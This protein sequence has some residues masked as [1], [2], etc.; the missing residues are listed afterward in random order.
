MKIIEENKWIIM[1]KDRK[2]IAKGIPRSRY[3]VP[4][5]DGTINKRLLTYSSKKRAESGFKNSWFYRR[6]I[7]VNYKEEDLE[8]IKIKITIEELEEANE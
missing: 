5:D 7:A 8:A 2:V 4:L 6:G 3:L 1:S